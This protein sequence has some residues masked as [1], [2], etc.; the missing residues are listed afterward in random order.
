VTTYDLHQHLW[1]AGFVAALRERTSPPQLAGDEL[2]TCEGR[3][4]LD[5]S[6]HDPGERVRRLDADGIDVAVLSLQPSLGLERLA[7]DECSALEDAWVD[8]IRTLLA[9]S[10]RF[11]A[12]SPSVL[13]DG[14]RGVTLGS[15][16]LLDLDRAA[17][18]LDAA[19]VADAEG[20]DAQFDRSP[21]VRR[22]LEE[23][24]RVERRADVE[25]LS[26][27]AL[28]LEGPAASEHRE[29]HLQARPALSSLG[30]PHDVRLLHA[31]RV[32]HDPLPPRRTIRSGLEPGVRMHED[33]GIGR[34]RGVEHG[35][36]PIEIEEHARPE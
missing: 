17:P 7:A 24:V 4:V 29:Q 28:E 22:D 16:M 32:A 26:C 33:D 14:F 36:R 2:V 35:C 27:E 13:R 10:T 34:G 3:F 18:V 21:A 23:G 20:L 15:S 31:R 12:F 6:D 8:G 11:A 5:L 1:P 30:E 19:A 25:P 9:E